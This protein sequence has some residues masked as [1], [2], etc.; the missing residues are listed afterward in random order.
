MSNTEAQQSG[1]KESHQ[2]PLLM[3]L[4]DR[5]FNNRGVL[6]LAVCLGAGSGSGCMMKQAK[7]P[8]LATPIEI[9]AAQRLEAIIPHCNRAYLAQNQSTA[10]GMDLYA[11]EMR[12][13]TRRI[14]DR[15]RKKVNRPGDKVM[16]EHSAL[17]KAHARAAEDYLATM[18]DQLTITATGRHALRQ[19]QRKEQRQLSLNSNLPIHP[20]V[21]S[22][23][24]EPSEEGVDRLLAGHSEY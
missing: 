2:P 15:N 22:N 23:C 4:T 20:S 12:Q 16:P 5:I 14:D 17:W 7:Q 21:V 10:R 11:K 9:L 13:K 3:S 8:A 1:L 24:V 6:L 19:Q 18:R